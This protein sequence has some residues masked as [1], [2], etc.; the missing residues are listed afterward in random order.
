MAQKVGGSDG[1]PRC[2]QAVY[3]AEK[4]IG[5]GKVRRGMELLCGRDTFREGLDLSPRLLQAGL[6]RLQPGLG[7][8]SSGHAHLE[9]WHQMEILACL[10]TRFSRLPRT[11]RLVDGRE[12]HF[13]LNI[14][15]TAQHTSR[16]MSLLL[17]VLGGQAV[18]WA[19]AP[20]TT[21]SASAMS[22]EPSAPSAAGWD[23]A[24]RI[25]GRE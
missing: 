17:D 10:E 25:R 7:L 4:V 6:L 15:S 8:G 11:Y 14:W 22:S 23:T 2:G 9:A 5:A 18:M 24:A 21:N 19:M 16:W 1:C 3:A 12:M 20:A 13:I